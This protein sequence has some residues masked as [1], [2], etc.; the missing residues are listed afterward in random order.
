MEG[1]KKRETE[2]LK[3]VIYQPITVNEHF[4]DLDSNCKRHYIIVMSR[5]EI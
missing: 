2:R 5:L 4:L 1:T 3:Q